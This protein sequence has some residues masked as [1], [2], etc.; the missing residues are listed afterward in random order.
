MITQ[1]CI[2]Y[3]NGEWVIPVTWKS[4]DGDA[5]KDIYKYTPISN[6][7]FKDMVDKVLF[8]LIDGIYSNEYAEVQELQ[9]EEHADI[10]GVYQ[11]PYNEGTARILIP[12]VTQKEENPSMV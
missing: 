3:Y 9:A 8:C 6:M 11:V 10:D 1:S 4:P 2:R 7:P 5:T 12:R